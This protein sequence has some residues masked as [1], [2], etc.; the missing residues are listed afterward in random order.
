M[1]IA[2]RRQKNVGHP[3]LPRP[4]ALADLQ[5][6]IDPSLP[7]LSTATGEVA[8]RSEEFALPRDARGVPGAVMRREV[9]SS[10]AEAQLQLAVN[11][12][13]LDRNRDRRRSDPSRTF[14]ETD[15]SILR[16]GWVHGIFPL[17][18]A[19]DN[20]GVEG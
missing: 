5:S 3:A 13:A 18:F 9:F 12:G 4:A 14:M 7:S 20:V 19:G 16:S 8:R 1:G 15:S 6:L 11:V 10:G 17:S 2:I